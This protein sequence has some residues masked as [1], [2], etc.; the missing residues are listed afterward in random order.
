MPWTVVR[1]AD[2]TAKP[3]KNGGGTTRQIAATP[4]GATFADLDWS[5]SIAEIEQPGPFSEFPGI[6]RTIML[7]AGIE[8]ILDVDGTPHRLGAFETLAFSGDA[9]TVC[10]LPRGATRGLNLM[11]RRGRAAG[12]L[13]AVDVASGYETTVADG[14]A[15]VLV[16]LTPGLSLDAG[17]SLRS[18]DSATYDQPGSIRLTGNGS[19]AELRISA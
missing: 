13:R 16:A 3:W 12:S 8:M 17:P 10:S 6:D 7:I 11:T 4:T 5:V 9:V 1:W 19:L 18:L 15:V 2:L 14:E